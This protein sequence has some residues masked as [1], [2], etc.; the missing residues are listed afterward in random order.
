MSHHLIEAMEAGYN[1]PDGT[2]ALDKIA[3]RIDHGESVGIIGANG[4]GK[5]TLLLLLSGVLEPSSGE[6]RIGGIRLTVKNRSTVAGRM[7]LVFQDPDD[8][9]FMGTVGED[10]ALGPQSQGLEPDQVEDRVNRALE[11]AGISSL[12]DRPPYRLS[13][14]EKRAA[15]LASVLAMEPDVLLM[16]E[17]SSWLD[18]KSRRRLIGRLQGFEHTK[19]ITAHDLDLIWDLCQRTII[20]KDGRMLRDGPTKELLKDACLLDEAGLELPLSLRGRS[21]V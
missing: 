8:Q 3:F 15:A 20:L 21:E 17:P 19:I 6:I 4:A 10:V 7:G 1:Y 11:S 14:G 9:L 13:A 12:R 5:S 2:R 18:P 16:D